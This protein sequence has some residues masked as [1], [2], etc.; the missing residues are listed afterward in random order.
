M[1]DVRTKDVVVHSSASQHLVGVA[2]NDSAVLTSQSNFQHDFIHRSFF[3][4]SGAGLG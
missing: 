4:E 3:A 2:A 1:T